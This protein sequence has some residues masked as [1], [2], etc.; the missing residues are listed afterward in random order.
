MYLMY[1]DESGDD[2]L[3]G[4]PSKIFVLS[5]L[6]IHELMWKECLEQIIDFRKR[7]LSKYDLFMRDEIHASAFINHPGDLVRIKR[8]DRLS[9]LR[10]FA[11]EL[12]SI[13][14][15]NIINVIVHKEG[16]PLSYDIFENGWQVLI[17]RFENT[18]FY[19]NFTG[20]ANS[21][22]KGIIIPDNTNK[23]KLTHLIRKM[24]RYNPIPNL[25]NS[26]YRNLV[27]RNT[28]EDPFLRDSADSYFI[29]ASDLIAFLLYQYKYPNSFMRK[30][31][32][33]KYFERLEPILCKKAS[34][35]NPLGIVEI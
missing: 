5:G 24:R 13:P 26:G 28:I 12:A 8:N 35:M 34:K 1:V 33:D 7:M 10:L 16:K 6:V 4:S 9:I 20:P 30:K 3:A 18:I 17:Q 11:N 27:L 32:G 2:G 22:E 23:K 19:K 15:L 29:Q 31:A 25:N 14:Y 21:I